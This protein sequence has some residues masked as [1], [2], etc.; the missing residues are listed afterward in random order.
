MKLHYVTFAIVLSGGSTASS[1]TDIENFGKFLN[2][3]GTPT[4]GRKMSSLKVREGKKE[5]KK[6]DQRFVVVKVLVK[7]NYLQVCA[8][9]SKN[10]LNGQRP[11]NKIIQQTL[12]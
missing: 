5:V 4:I 3:K 8:Q 6:I 9:I 12:I 1:M 7:V 11:I 2:L 10:D